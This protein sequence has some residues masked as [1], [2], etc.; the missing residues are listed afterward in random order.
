MIKKCYAKIIG[1][2]YV[3]I[4]MSV[5]ACEKHVKLSDEKI[6]KTITA[7]MKKNDI[8]G[9]AIEVYRNGVPNSYYF[10][11]AD[12][13]KKTPVTEK[14]I[15][16][17]GSFTK[18]F[19]SIL[20]A[21]EVNAGKMS[22]NDPISK[23]TPDLAV[24]SDYLDDITL[25]NLATHTSGLPFSVANE[26]KTRSQ[27]PGY[28][29]NWNPASPI[30]SQWAYSNINIGLLGYAL[31]ASTHENINELYRNKLLK[32]LGMMPI[33]IIVPQEFEK[34]YAQGYNEDGK[35]VSHSKSSLFP[36]AGAMKASGDDML[37]FLKASLQLP[38]TPEKISDA[39][40]LTQIAYAKTN[41]MSQGMAWLIY[42][43]TPKNQKDLLNPEMNRS[44]G[45]VDAKFIDK[46]EQRYDGNALIDKT[47]GTEGFRSYI[48]IIPNRQSGVVILANRYI[49]NGEIIKV[50]REILFS[51][52]NIEKM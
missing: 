40:R 16:E 45:P 27:L 3:S 12:R 33:G 41:T 47:G 28:F 19:T 52:D 22:L 30:G 37:Q 49:S 10:G 48:A 26:T 20:L 6:N 18:L 36:A 46:S 44:M 29:S 23:Y 42:P 11:Y 5:N 50:G 34:N 24:S 13:N 31:E 25:L 17:V 43:I 32:P 7:W 21:E 38:G 39:V 1:I 9:V 2:M 35:A 51:F 14:T 8:P 15:F 4:A